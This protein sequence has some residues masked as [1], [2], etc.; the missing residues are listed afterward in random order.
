[1]IRTMTECQFFKEML[2]GKQCDKA[3]TCCSIK[4]KALCGTVDDV[5]IDMFCNVV[6]LISNVISSYFLKEITR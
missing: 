5:G 1:M 2:C 4:I 6:L 3:F